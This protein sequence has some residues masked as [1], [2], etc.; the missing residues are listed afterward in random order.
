MASKGD[1]VAI[2][3][4]RKSSPP[5]GVSQMALR[6]RSWSPSLALRERQEFDALY[7]VEMMDPGLDALLDEEERIRQT[8]REESQD[9]NDS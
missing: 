3:Q 1:L 2:L 6:E 7:G 4:Q 9:Q 8:L 5:V